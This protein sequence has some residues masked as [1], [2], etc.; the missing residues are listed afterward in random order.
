MKVG[1]TIQ[2]KRYPQNGLF[3]VYETH[4]DH[5]H[6]YDF[7]IV[8]HPVDNPHKLATADAK[9]YRVVEEA[10]EN[11]EQVAANE[12]QAATEAIKAFVKARPALIIKPNS[13]TAA[14][15]RPLQENLF[16]KLYR[17]YTLTKVPNATSEA[18]Y[19]AQ[20]V[21]DAICIKG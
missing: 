18:R 12:V 2:L 10:T 7:Q 4:E 20:I 11:A 6:G 16:W 14:A 19:A 3:K 13:P 9:Y 15:L 8:Y 21:T 17:L 1:D 5:S